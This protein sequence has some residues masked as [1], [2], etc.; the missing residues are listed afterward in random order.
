MTQVNILIAVI[1]VTIR[2]MPGFPAHGVSWI[3]S[4]EALA[5]LWAGAYVGGAVVYWRCRRYGLT[6]GC[7][8]CASVSFWGALLATAVEGVMFFVQVPYPWTK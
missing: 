6:G 7:D 5:H 8:D 4:Y 2:L 3:G 1:L